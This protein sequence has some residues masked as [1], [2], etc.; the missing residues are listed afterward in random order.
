MF[1]QAVVDANPGLH[2]CGMR[3]NVIVGG[4][5]PLIGVDCACRKVLVQPS[6]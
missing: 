6:W 1:L 5:L 2:T 3:R 4:V